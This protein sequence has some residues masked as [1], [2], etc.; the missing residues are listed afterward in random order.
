MGFAI[1]DSSDI[2]LRGN[3]GNGYR[4][5]Q[6][7]LSRI[8]NDITSVGTIIANGYKSVFHA[9][10]KS[11]QMNLYVYCNGTLKKVPSIYP[12]EY[13]ISS[14]GLVVWRSGGVYLGTPGSC[15]PGIINL[16]LD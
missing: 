12:S 13:D 8:S 3:D 14:S 15:G 1:T 9:Y 10:D 5:S 4:Y 6:G 16:L 11:N 7:I 2:L